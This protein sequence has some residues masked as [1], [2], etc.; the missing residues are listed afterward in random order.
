[1][2]SLVSTADA[3]SYLGLADSGND[4]VFNL[5]VNAASDAVLQALNGDPRSMQVTE[6]HDGNG[7]NAMG[8]NR[9]P[10]TAVASV[11]INTSDWLQ[12]GDWPYDNSAQTTAY[13]IPIANLYASDYVIYWNAGKFPR[14]SK[15]IAFT[16]TAG[17]TTL[18]SQILMATMFTI[19]AMWNAVLVDP[20]ATSESYAGVL[21][22]G[23]WSTGPGSVPPQA[24]NLLTPFMNK[25][26]VT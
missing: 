7:S 21:S 8:M 2:A 15:N 6:L 4:F 17:Y 1:M 10:I 19:K 26:K 20:N 13:S 14:G 18:P 12:N 23:F 22:Q 16:Y 5:V 25:F 9:F 3:L 24:I 11:Q